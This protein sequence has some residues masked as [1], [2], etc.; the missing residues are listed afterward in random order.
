VREFFRHNSP[1]SV[2][3]MR[4]RDVYFQG[5][6]RSRSSTTILASSLVNGLAASAGALAFFYYKW[7]WELRSI[8]K[9]RNTGGGEYPWGAWYLRRYSCL[10][11]S[12]FRVSV[13]QIS[14]PGGILQRSMYLHFRHDDC[15]GMGAFRGNGGGR[16]SA[17][18]TLLT[19]CA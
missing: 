11:R 3:E 6:L 17:D 9:F 14:L 12:R 19:R 13:C 18:E 1:H 8:L 5:T 10:R 2:S 4:F 15:D 7:G 16:L